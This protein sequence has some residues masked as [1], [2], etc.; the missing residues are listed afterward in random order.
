[1]VVLGAGL[2]CSL[3]ILLRCVGMKKRKRKNGKLT[4]PL[5]LHNRHCKHRFGNR[6]LKEPTAKAYVFYP[7]LSCQTINVKVGD[8][9][10]QA[11]RLRADAFTLEDTIAKNASKPGKSQQSANLQLSSKPTQYDYAKIF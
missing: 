9:S 5:C 3:L 10:K 4:I 7:E 6:P 2:S 1:M 11:T 8:T